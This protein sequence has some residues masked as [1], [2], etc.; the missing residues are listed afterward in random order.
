MVSFVDFNLLIQ[1]MIKV[2]KHLTLSEMFRFF[3]LRFDAARPGKRSRSTSFS[4]AQRGPPPT[5]GAMKLSTPLVVTQKTRQLTETAAAAAG[6]MNAVAKYF[7]LP[8]TLSSPLVPNER[9]YVRI[10]FFSS[11]VLVCLILFLSSVAASR[12]YK[13]PTSRF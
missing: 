5:L 10:F 12:A 3:A 2:A 8:S 1:E 13:W 9:L 7:H 6:Y 11:S 4:E